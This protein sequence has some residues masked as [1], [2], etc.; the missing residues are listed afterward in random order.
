[1]INLPCGA[2]IT[3]AC[4]VNGGSRRPVC[5]DRRPGR[6][7]AARVGTHRLRRPPIY[8]LLC[9][10]LLLLV[11]LTA[12]GEMAAARGGPDAGQSLDV[13]EAQLQSTE[14]RLEELRARL[15]DREAYRDALYGELERYDRDVAALARTGHELAQRHAAQQRL[16][17][18]LDARLR[19][20]RT[21]LGA[22]RTVLAAML[23]SAYA[24]G[25]GDR[26]R[27]LLNQQD[28]GRAGRQL[29]YFRAVARLRAA[30]VAEVERLA[31]ELDAL[32]RRAAEEVA[33]L[34]RLTAQE[35][36]TLQALEAARTARGA[37]LA[38]LD[39]A[40]ADDQERV[41]ELDANAS[42][43]RALVSELRK[44]ARIANEIAVKQEVLAARRG[45]LSPPIAGARVVRSYAGNARPGDLHADGVLFGADPGSE[46]FPVHHGQVVY[47]DWLRGFG[48]L[49]VI[50]HGDGYMTL[51]GHN[52]A[53]L[54]DV[55]EWVGPDDVVALS[56]TPSGTDITT[57]GGDA[58]G[59]LYF[60]LRRDGTPLNPTT[61]FARGP[62]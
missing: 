9:L 52:Q 18:D 49:M 1:M 21:E 12:I 60:A 19:Q 6:D 34:A 20:T 15:T 47:A 44:R 4:L 29:G 35:R 27:L 10:P 30:R 14:A 32:R 43:L 54:K 3:P 51:Y 16:V 26:L 25:P 11:P 62:G 31:T 37:V 24:A 2:L 5:G 48:L 59:R 7:L 39:A 23:R 28:P 13:H 56:G 50:D 42:A 22:A 40:I 38:D 17:A 36:R 57:A 58:G 45:K 55:G 46:V 41:A 33:S 61:W 53:L 8:G